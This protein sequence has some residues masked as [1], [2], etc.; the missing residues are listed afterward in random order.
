MRVRD[1]AES[2]VG[3]TPEAPQEPRGGRPPRTGLGWAP[4]RAGRTV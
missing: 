4:P 3:P 2:G 1:G